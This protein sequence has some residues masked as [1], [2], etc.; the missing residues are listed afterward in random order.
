VRVRRGRTWAQLGHGAAEHDGRYLRRVAPERLV[1]S[2]R[3]RPAWTTKSVV[4]PL[5]PRS[6][7]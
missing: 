2:M 4:A 3:S 5:K 6:K 1:E 7:A